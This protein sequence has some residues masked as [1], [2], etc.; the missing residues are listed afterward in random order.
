MRRS[1][2]FAAAL[3]ALGIAGVGLPRRKPPRRR[4]RSTGSRRPARSPSAIATTR[5][6]SRTR[7]AKAGSAATASSFALRVAGAIQKELGLSELKIE[8]LPVEASNRLDYVTERQGRRRLRHDDDHAVADEE[9]RFQPA[10]LRRRRQRARAREIEARPARRPQGQAHR[11]DRAARRRSRSSSARLNA[12]GAPGVLVPVKNG[13]EGMAMLTQGQGR[14][15][16]GDRVVLA[17]LKLRAPDPKCLHVRRRRFLVRAVRLAHAPG[18]PRFQARGE[19]R[20]GRASIAA[21][22][23]TRSSSAGSARWAC[24]GRCCTRCSTSTPCRSDGMPRVP[25]RRLPI[26]VFAVAVLATVAA[27]AQGPAQGLA[28]A[29]AGTDAPDCTSFP[30]GTRRI[31]PADDGE[32]AVDA[33]RRRGFRES[34]RQRHGKGDTVVPDRAGPVEPGHGDA[35]APAAAPH[36]GSRRTPTIS[37]AGR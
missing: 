29:Q 22:T 9:G 2:L 3:L 30:C 12:L 36:T 14:R 28:Q 37:R 4:R 33:A 15:L 21:A 18:R 20:A 35:R 17:Y 1:T 10:D 26:L 25:V 19:P 24:P 7:T 23:S 32:A 11:G 8:W 31:D 5:C 27:Q 13:A 34:R 6:R 16:R